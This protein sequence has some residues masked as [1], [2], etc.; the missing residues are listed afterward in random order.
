MFTTIIVQPIFNLLV[1]IYNLIPGHNFGLAVIIFTI[2]V[3]LL[4]WP[5]VKKQL[6]QA[7]AMRQLAPELKK[8]KA[9]AAGD[10]QKISKLTMELY[11]ERQINPFASL[12]IVLVQAPILIGLYFAIQ[13]L[14]KNPQEII[15]FSYSF[16]HFGW[17]DTLATNIHLFDSSLFGAVDLTR[18][19]LSPKGTYLPA[20]VIVA[21]SAIVQYFQS[22]QLMP[23]AKDARSLRT[24]LSEA[25]Q[26]KQADQSEVTAAVGRGTLFLI[27]FFVF[28]IGLNFPAALPLYWLVSSS[29]A[30]IQQSKVLREDVAEAEAV[31]SR[32]SKRLTEQ[33]PEKNRKPDRSGGEIK[34]TKSGVK[35]YRLSA[36]EMRERNDRR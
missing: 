36:R 15:D 5:L 11:K 2:I 22:K 6:H 1:F 14:I 35:V 13:R 16:L 30:L 18:S 32:E 8:I 29:V 28:V 34:T 21:L 3:R 7:K 27:P 10:R 33:A 12:G 25:G 9:A 24:I 31:V 19:A 26:G 20:L 4:M 17:L 23:A